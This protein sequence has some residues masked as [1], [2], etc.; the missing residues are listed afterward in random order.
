MKNSKKTI[1]SLVAALLLST[2]VGQ[3]QGLTYTT[4]TRLFNPNGNR[5]TVNFNSDLSNYFSNII[6]KLRPTFNWDFDNIGNDKNNEQKEPEKPV[7]PEPE[8][9]EE[10]PQQ[11]QKPETPKKPEEKP[12]QPSNPQPEKPSK[13]VEKPSNTNNP[14]SSIEREVARLVN[15][16]RQK[17]GLA[18]LT[19][20][21]ELSKVARIKSQDMADKNYFSHT[22]PTYGD[23]FQ[24]MRSFGISYRYAGENIAKGY[25]S[26]ESVM[27]GWMNSS[28]HRAN[29]LNVNFGKIGVGYVE[30]NGT[31][32]WTQMFTD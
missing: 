11:P 10:K 13:P 17:A 30:T 31:T 2:T 12:Q 3:A 1:I 7:N 15:L 14:S 16:E 29:I 4:K 23:P 25:R 21:E 26:A 28:G 6:I 24:M 9:P 22:S 8:T 19:F 32:Y 5:Y 27:N 20:S 18:P